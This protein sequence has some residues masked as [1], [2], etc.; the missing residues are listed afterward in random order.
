MEEESRG[1]PTPTPPEVNPIDNEMPVIHLWS[2]ESFHEEQ[3]IV[4][5][6]SGLTILFNSLSEVLEKRKSGVI[7]DK[8]FTN[9]GEGYDLHIIITEDVD[10]LAIPYTES[11]AAE[12]RENAIYPYQ[13]IDP[14]PL[15]GVNPLNHHAKKRSD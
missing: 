14:V 10:P 9:D 2:P 7:K 6:E 3:F 15:P 4:G 8:L 12:H 11:Y 13:M 1:S 5:N